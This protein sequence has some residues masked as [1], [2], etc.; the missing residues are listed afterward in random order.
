M[1]GASFRPKSFSASS[2]RYQARQVRAVIVISQSGQAK[3]EKARYRGIPT[4]DPAVPGARGAYPLPK[5]AA[6]NLMNFSFRG[7]PLH[8]E[9]GREIPHTGAQLTLFPLS[10]Q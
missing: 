8:I 3:A 7:C 2:E 10:C 5:P 4:S 1:H 6:A 9:S